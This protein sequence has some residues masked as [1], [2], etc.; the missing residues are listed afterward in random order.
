MKKIKNENVSI[1]F[2]LHYIVLVTLLQNTLFITSSLK[3]MIL[4]IFWLWLL[5]LV[6]L[7]VQQ[8]VFITRFHL[9]LMLF[10]FICL[11]VFIIF[12]FLHQHEKQ[13][14]M[15][16]RILLSTSCFFSYEKIYKS[17]SMSTHHWMEFT[18]FKMN[19]APR[20]RR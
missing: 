13:N 14:D 19:D 3:K 5:W 18:I 20:R 4:F 9:V 7:A 11:F 15:F 2:G 12:I 17:Y 6:L 8:N 10:L 16:W 1:N